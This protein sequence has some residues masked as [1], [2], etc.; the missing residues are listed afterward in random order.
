[1]NRKIQAG[2]TAKVD[3]LAIF[4]HL[5]L[6]K[7]NNSSVFLKGD[8]SLIQSKILVDNFHSKE[9]ELSGQI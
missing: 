6:T 7:G 8:S 2:T 1:M 5:L 9:T 4:P 3:Y